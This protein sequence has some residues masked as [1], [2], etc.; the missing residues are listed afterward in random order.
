MRFVRYQDRVM[1]SISSIEAEKKSSASLS[2]P[3]GELAESALRAVLGLR[4][5]C[6]VCEI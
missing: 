2:G 5:L 6:G 3:V 1:G 4:L